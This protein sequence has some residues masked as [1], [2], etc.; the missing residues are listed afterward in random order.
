MRRLT[1]ILAALTVLAATPASNGVATEPGTDP[2]DCLRHLAGLD[3]QH[4]T[5]VDLQ[6]ALEQGDITSRE[7]VERY[8]ERIAAF[9]GAGPQLNGIRELHPDVLGQADQLD[10][11][12]RAGHVRGPMHGIPVLLKDNIGTG[13]MPT[14]AGSIALE[15]N[16]P[17]N[18]AF[19]VE[20]L[21]EEGAII[22][23]KAELAEF[24][25]WVDLRMP[26]GYSS[27][28]GQVLNSYDLARNPSGSSSGP[29]TAG[30]MAYATVTIGSETSGSILSPAE[31]QGLAAV[32]PT[33]GLVSRSGVIPLAPSWDTTGPMTRNITDAAALL[34]A[35]AGVDPTD[36]RSLESR[37]HLP[38]ALDYLP[39]LRTDVLEGVRLGV[40]DR[41]PTSSVLREAYDELETQ[42]ATLVEIDN[43]GTLGQV[44]LAE[45]GFVANEFKAYLDRYLQTEANPPTGVQSLYDVV[46]YS[47]EHSDRYPYGNSLLVASA[48][49]PGTVE[50]TIP[51]SITVTETSRAI[52]DDTL[53]QHDL[54][55]IVSS[56]T[57]TVRI[58]AAAGYPT[59]AVPA[60]ATGN[61]H[62][63]INLAF[64]STAWTEPQLLSFAY[65]YEQA[66]LQR[67]PPTEVNAGAL[68]TEAC[69]DGGGGAH[70]PVQERDTA[71]TDLRPALVT[72]GVESG[73]RNSTPDR[74]G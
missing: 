66:T 57:G 45:L 1:L 37:P 26:N 31:V 60:G 5:V 33:V 70:V 46:L 2:V 48:A 50:S 47:Q 35:T 8:L 29:A 21:R 67:V 58:G 18:D 32:K 16:I 54:N 39:F 61:G 3:L 38:P 64:L 13:D 24:A 12:R 41:T 19:L 40:T 62:R 11:E 55:A 7:L 20:R 27:L 30:A 68:V 65:D 22:L 63:P 42:G 36:P 56:G 72:S 74:T 43:F 34:S 59:V 10:A 9:D 73:L 25:N 71:P 69:P 6:E 52:I 44:G 49:Q 53:A 15:G 23:G 51:G 28:G 4:V 17:D 14:T